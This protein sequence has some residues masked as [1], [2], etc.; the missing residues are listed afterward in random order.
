MALGL[1]F[2]CG[3]GE[4]VDSQRLGQTSVG[5]WTGLLGALLTPGRATKVVRLSELAPR[6]SSSLCPP[7][8]AG[9]GQTRAYNLATAPC[10][11]FFARLSLFLL[12]GAHACAFLH[13]CVLMCVCVCVNVCVCLHLCEC[14]CMFVSRSFVRMFVR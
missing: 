14:K 8:W 7:V 1:T 12:R 11:I 5:N 3:G 13:T 9:G 10:F 2:P 4:W 6:T